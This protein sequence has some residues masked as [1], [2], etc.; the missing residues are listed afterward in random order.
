VQLRW[1]IVPQPSFTRPASPPFLEPGPSADLIT[2]LQRG[3]TNNDPNLLPRP[4]QAIVMKDLCRVIST[5]Y[6][7]NSYAYGPI[8]DAA[9]QTQVERE[10]ESLVEQVS[11]LF[12]DKAKARHKA[13]L[14]LAW[15]ATQLYDER[16]LDPGQT[17][18]MIKP[19]L[20]SPTIQALF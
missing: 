11:T 3:D 18:R 16:Q 15:Q 5:D 13:E 17:C 4:A 6:P 10:A 14:A 12:T 19:L 1:R 7:P 9:R 20:D 2:M 8:K